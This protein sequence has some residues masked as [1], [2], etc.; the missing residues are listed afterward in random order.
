MQKKYLSAS[1]LN[2]SAAF[3]LSVIAI[4]SYVTNSSAETVIVMPNIVISEASDG[5]FIEL[6]QAT[7]TRVQKAA[8]KKEEKRLKRERKK[9]ER[10]A[11]RKKRAK[12]K[13]GGSYS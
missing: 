10:D 6:A 2:L 9:A 3:V 4:T 13:K 7:E 11:K 12:K 8:R 1:F 5:N